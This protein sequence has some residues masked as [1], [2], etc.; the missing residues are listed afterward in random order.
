MMANKKSRP[1]RKPRGMSTGTP[2]RFIIRKADDRLGP[3][4]HIKRSNNK[5]CLS[6][7]DK[8]GEAAALACNDRLP[9]RHR[10]KDDER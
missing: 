4:I 7:F 10:L 6:I 9:R 5:A 2:K 8:L 1:R 3:G